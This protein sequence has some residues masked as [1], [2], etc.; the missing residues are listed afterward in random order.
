MDRLENK[1]PFILFLLWF[2]FFFLPIGNRGLWDPDEPRYLQVAWEMAK[3]KTYL[4]PIFNGELYSHKPPLFFWLTILM[5]KLSAFETA[6][7]YVSAL[8]SLGTIFLTYLM[9]K[10]YGS[11]KIGFVA[12]LILM[13]S[14]L[15]LWLS[16]TGNIDM[17]LTLFT[18]LSFF[19][20]LRYEE[21]KKH[22][23]ILLAYISCGIGVLAKGPVAL[24]VPWL[25]FLVWTIYN[26]YRNKEKVS[27][28]HLI[29][30]PLLVLGI[31]ALWV[32]PAYVT[33]GEEYTKLILIKQN[34][35]RTVDSF[36]HQSPWYYYLINFTGIF[37]PWS[38]VFLAILFGLKK[39]LKETQR[40][41]RFYFIWFCTVFIFFS[42]LSGKRGLYLIPAY[43]AFS[44]FLAHMI[45]RWEKRGETSFSLKLCVFLV[46]A[47]GVLFFI[48][49]SIIPFLKEKTALLSDVSFTISGWRL[50]AIYG[51]GVLPI[52][53]LWASYAK[54]KMQKN[55]EASM[56]FALSILLFLSIADISIIPNI[57][58]LKSVKYFVDDMQG[59]I[60]EDSTLAF[61]KDYSQSGWNFYLNRPVIPVVTS[62][63]IKKRM[64]PPY[65]FV[66]KWKRVNG[67]TPILPGDNSPPKRIG[68][69]E[70]K[71][72]YVKNLGSKEYTLW[73]LNPSRETEKK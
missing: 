4:I 44:L 53:M 28:S 31:A 50:W 69:Y 67:R 55:M 18:T 66:L 36:A 21:D 25:S 1:Y 54:L 58:P 17:T 2:V 72:V 49:P 63:Q 5:S 3:A 12:A 59:K 24:L 46:F 38:L 33:G 60:S 20:F 56:F 47:C 26:R 73:E 6:S 27:I 42:L 61:Y 37:A 40:L 51:I 71:T 34:L 68:N 41:Q 11:R 43:P 35:G 15:Y 65:D 23:W 57:D 64:N 10:R 32:I 19:S 70:Y 16:G 22:L 30:G 45:S 8:M 39:E 29:W 14:G 13:T 62:K 9:G 48:F 52:L 7:R